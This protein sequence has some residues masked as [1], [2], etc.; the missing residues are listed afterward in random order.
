MRTML[1]DWGE[2]IR[3]ED[4]FSDSVDGR[5]YAPIDARDIARV[6]ACLLTEPGHEGPP[7]R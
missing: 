4:A 6:A 5:A 2:T 7:T 1:E 3:T